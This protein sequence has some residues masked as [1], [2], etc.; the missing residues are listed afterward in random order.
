[1]KLQTLKIP[2]TLLLIMIL[3]STTNGYNILGLFTIPI[4]S[5]YYFAET[6]LKNLASKGHNVTVVSYFPQ[7]TPLENFT[8]ISIKGPDMKNFI[9]LSIFEPKHFHSSLE[10][11]HRIQ[12]WGL[13]DCEAAFQSDAIAK[14]LTMKH[15]FDVILVEEFNNDCILAITHL[16]DAPVVS[17]SSCWL[18]PWL[19][20]RMQTPYF[21]SFWPPNN[22]GTGEKMNFLERVKCFLYH[23]YSIFWFQTVTKFKTN[24]I[25]RKYL[26]DSIPDVDEI[27]RKRTVLMLINQ[28]FS[29]TGVKA[30]APT[31][32]E[33]GGLQI[34]QAKTLNPK[35]KQILDASKNGVI[36]VNWGSMVR[37]SSI[38][39]SKR[40]ELVKA[41]GRLKQTVI[42]KWENET[43]PNQPK[44]VHIM[45]WTQ[46][47]EILS[48]PNV[49]VFMSHGGLLGTS[50]AT[51]YGV[52][53]IA[54]PIFGDQFLNSKTLAERG[55]GLT[56]LFDDLTEENIYNSIQTALKSEFQQ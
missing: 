3:C 44:N 29:L 10:E 37:K 15:E 41:F 52:P 18:M 7:K 42:W 13:K 1:M 47:R 55:M 40:E 38:P 35:M 8:D 4:A 54:T 32:I 27:A 51:Y 19:Y 53:I 5:H 43:L 45:K 28:H 2:I 6:L 20:D 33:V 31:V 9:D 49:K 17:L 56:L 36:Y 39:A 25:V 22:C 16:L 14:I 11:F 48:H 12:D 21:V 30:Y 23:H 50:E 46:Q 34:E 26:G 24:T